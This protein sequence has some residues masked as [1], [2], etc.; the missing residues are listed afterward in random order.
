MRAASL[1]AV[2]LCLGAGAPVVPA[3]PPGLGAAVAA[4][5]GGQLASKQSAAIV[6]GVVSGGRLVYAR[7]FGNATPDSTFAIGSV[8]KIFTAVSVMQLV[9]RGKLSLSDPISKYLPNLTAFGAVTVRQLL[10]HTSGIPNYLD[11]ALARFENVTKT[12][13][14][15]ILASV[16]ARRLDFTP[17]TDWNYSNTGYV[18]LGQIVERVTGLSL[19]EY[20]KRNIF[21]PLGMQRTT[22]GPVAKNAPAAPFNGDPGDWSWYYADGDIFSTIGDLAR[23]DIALM[24]G[25]VLPHPFFEAMQQTVPY[26]TLTVGL[27]D[28]EGLFVVEGQQ[29]HIAGHHGGLAG[30]RADN[31]MV[32][33][34]D[35]A[36]IVLGNGAYDTR[37][38]VHA[39]LKTYIPGYSPERNLAAQLQYD[40][41][42]DVTRRAAA[43]LAGAAVGHWDRSQF[44]P[45]VSIQ[46]PADETMMK[47]LAPLGRFERLQFLSKAYLQSGVYYVYSAVFAHRTI[48]LHVV[49]DREG[50]FVGFSM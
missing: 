28:A 22:S 40:P 1:A 6:V 30:Y 20:E 35:F 44:E 39:A 2:A 31:E 7:A 10:N 46:L 17:G 33:A 21:E 11:D 27:R 18:A 26:A 41:A 34:K 48:A 8:T 9:S 37:P 36:V 5:A 14:Q 45:L 23:F 13:P 4:A 24:Q 47:Q 15:A 16:A 43:L 42:P 38:M 3:V 19:A 12:T 29:V 49:L 32:P 50:K 25:K